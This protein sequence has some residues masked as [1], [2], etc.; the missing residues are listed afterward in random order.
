[1]TTSD[2]EPRN[3]P[4]KAAVAP[5]SAYAPPESFVLKSISDTLEKIFPN[6]A[7]HVRVGKNN[8]AGKA[9]SAEK[10]IAKS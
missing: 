1:M 2:I 8:P 5:T 6:I 9:H 3:T 10:T 7:P 4:A